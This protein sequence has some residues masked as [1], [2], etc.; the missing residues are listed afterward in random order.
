[1]TTREI[2]TS[3]YYDLV[4]SAF[5]CNADAIGIG[6]IFEFPHK[7]EDGED[8]TVRVLARDSVEALEI[9][10]SYREDESAGLPSHYATQA[11][12]IHP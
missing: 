2:I 11:F 7:D 1:M 3:G 9:F 6:R 5:Q 10:D 12:G 4:S 8:F